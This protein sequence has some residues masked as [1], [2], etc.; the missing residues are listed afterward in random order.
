MHASGTNAS[1]NGSENMAITMPPA[2]PIP[3]TMTGSRKPVSESMRGL[4]SLTM[5]SALFVM[6]IAIAVKP[7]QA[8]SGSVLYNFCYT[9]YC[10]D[11]MHPESRLTT[12][13]SGNF[14]GTT[15][16]GGCT[17]SG[18]G[19]GVVFEL[20]PN[21][22]ENGGET[23]LYTFCSA[24][25]CTDGANPTYSYVIF[26]SAGNLY[27]TTKYGGA[28]G[29]GVV[30]EL[31]S[32][33][34]TWTET[35]L[36]SFTGGT[37]GSF[38]VNGLILDAAGNLYGTVTSTQG[39]SE[40]GGVFELSPS[41]SGG[42]TEQ[43]IYNV[44]G[45]PGN[46]SG[47]AMDSAGNIFGTTA[48]T[49]FELSQKVGAGWTPTVIYT[50]S[51]NGKYGYLPENAPVLD[52]AGNLFGTTLNGGAKNAGAVY[53]L[54]PSKKGKWKEKVLYSFKGK[55]DSANPW[56]GVVLDAAGNIY[57]TTTFP[58]N[59]CHCAGTVFELVATAGKGPYKE[60]VLWDFTRSSGGYN[61]L[62]SL[63]LDSAGNLYGTA[64]YGGADAYGGPD[65]G[66][67]FEVT[68]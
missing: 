44:S 3:I 41:G 18:C 19:D 16:N 31:S 29:Y 58:D 38:P 50:F 34:G 27:G 9:G 10:S 7:A 2:T 66:V 37:D 62:G 48:S 21:G 5:L 13:G 60:K 64:E 4:L 17:A 67:I 63:L 12:D 28:Y 39:G 46:Y 11:G 15:T 57:G 24:P 33:A 55:A 59:A 52:K 22:I 23:V 20:S 32:I 47:L 6:V 61:P 25:N 40:G 65:S 1:L 42:W 51:V 49:V 54:I 68:P 53:E 26:D 30:F 56:G 45:G 35:V 36:Y 8:Q 14:Y 43:L